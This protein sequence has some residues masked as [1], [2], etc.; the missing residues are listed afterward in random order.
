MKKICVGLLMLG[1]V[2]Q[3]A[4]A[5]EVPMITADSAITGTMEIDFKTRTDRDQTGKYKAGSPSLG[6]GDTY[7]FSIRVGQT[8]DYVGTIVR[9]PELLTSTFLRSAQPA[10]LKFNVDLGLFNPKNLSER[11]SAGKWV[12]IVPIDTKTGV[13]SLST[14][15][16]LLRIDCTAIGRQAAFKDYF[17]GR[18]LGK[19]IKKEGFA[20]Y[21]Y[22]R[23]VGGKQVEIVAK[24][25]DP[26]R[27]ENLALAKGPFA[28]YPKTVVNGRLDYDYETGNWLTDGV[29]FTY[30]LNGQDT[31]DVMTGSIK[32]IESEDRL[33]SGKGYYDFN[34][35]FNE[36][37][38]KGASEN[39]AFTNLS[40]EDAFFAI[41]KSIP[42]ITGKISYEDSFIAGTAE[43]E[44]PIPS[45]SKVTFD[46]N[47]NHVSKIQ[48]ANFFKLWLICIGPINDE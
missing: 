15:T 9:Q 18:L 1:L 5:Q 24:Q 42:C 2:V 32:W 41:D 28:F 6:V 22:K 7:K 11:A 21:T 4:F 27:F 20:A 44:D 23:F 30:N 35:R 14:G 46:L 43:G 31:T 25:V 39:E 38:N 29:K 19:G 13:Y 3:A 33:T 48:A 26:M 47:A 37:S 10:Q 40:E 12:G 34:L 8:T 45:S 36:N 16:S 17:A